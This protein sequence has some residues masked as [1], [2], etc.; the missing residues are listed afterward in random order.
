MT[1]SDSSVEHTV[2]HIL[3]IDT[4]GLEQ[5]Y[6]DKKKAGPRLGVDNGTIQ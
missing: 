5:L 2:W 4:L 3:N 6:G 1:A